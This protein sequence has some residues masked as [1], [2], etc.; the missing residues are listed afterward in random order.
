MPKAK[1]PTPKQM[2]KVIAGN[3]LE[4]LIEYQNVGYNFSYSDGEGNFLHQAMHYALYSKNSIKIIELLI[5]AGVDINGRN[6]AGESPLHLTSTY[7]SLVL[8]L[9]AGADVAPKNQ[10]GET[11]VFSVV[12]SDALKAVDAATTSKA[13]DYVMTLELKN[14]NIDINPV[15]NDGLTPLAKAIEYIGLSEEIITSFK[16]LG[17]K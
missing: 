2:M 7:E 14:R 11:F 12:S 16:K 15:N 1:L 6:D 9:D 8:L 3:D 17:C 10:N 4:K 5:K 13:Y